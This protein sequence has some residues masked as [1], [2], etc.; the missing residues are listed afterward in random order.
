MKDRN[1]SGLTVVGGRPNDE[2][3]AASAM[4]PGFQTLLER[5]AANPKLARDLV[6]DPEGTLASEGL[7]LTA[8][9]SA[10]LHHLDPGDLEQAR[11]MPRGAMRSRSL[12]RAGRRAPSD[13][14]EEERRLAADQLEAVAPFVDDHDFYMRERMRGIRP[15]SIFP[16]PFAVAEALLRTSQEFRAAFLA[17]PRKTI[18]T[19]LKLP[20]SEEQ[21]QVLLVESVRKRLER[22]ARDV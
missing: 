16:T 9:E 17:D 19:W 10:M 20:L 2:E 18:L 8:A 3:Q 14:P 21:R 1:S 15:Q 6:A 12:G 4:S 22:V 13:A 5:L 11:S 7:T